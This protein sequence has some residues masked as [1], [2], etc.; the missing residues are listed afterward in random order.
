MKKFLW[1]ILTSFII[2][3]LTGCDEITST[4]T[5]NEIGYTKCT[6]SEKNAIAC[7]AELAPVCGSNWI[8]YDNACF[9]CVDWDVDSYK[10][11]NCETI[12]NEEYWVCSLE[13]TI[14]SEDI[15]EWLENAPTSTIDENTNSQEIW[16]ELNVVN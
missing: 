5:W 14:N 11:W 3:P 16:L 6:M 15:G 12:C 9:A 4:N 2:F 10:D 7:T 13:D 8:T 1:L